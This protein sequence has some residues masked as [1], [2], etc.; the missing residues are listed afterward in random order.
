[1]NAFP[2]VPVGEVCVARPGTRDPGRKPDATFRY[3]DI[4]AVDNSAKKIGTAKT[5]LGRNAPSRA[6]KV[7]RTGDVI[8]SMTRPNLNAVAL[9]SPDLDGEICSTGFG[10]LRATDRILPEYL[11]HFVTSQPFVEAASG[12]VSGALYPAIT[13]SYLRSIPI[14]LPPIEEQRRI[15]DILNRAASIER[16]RAQAS[17]HLLAFIPALFIK[18]F[19][20]P[21]ENP[22]GW[23]VRPLGEVLARIEGGW[24]PRCDDRVP[25]QCEWGVL[26]LSAVTTGTYDDSE[27][28]ALRADT[29]S[30]PEIDVRDGDVLF[31]RKNTKQLVG[32]CAWVRSTAPHRMFP[33]TIF[34]LVPDQVALEPAYLWGVLSQRAVRPAIERIA[35]GAA[36]SMVNI[37][38]GRLLGLAVPVPPIQAQKRFSDLAS[39]SRASS[40]TADMAAETASA[41]SRS[42]MSRLFHQVQHEAVESEHTG[43]RMPPP[44]A[45]ALG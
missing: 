43:E 17:D 39:P 6:R 23:P 22:M 33:Y 41:L 40:H 26:K 38:K 4:A 25:Q 1:M 35:T 21:V 36:A 16:L 11:F 30:R 3:V 24:S 15:V 14:P 28:K 31:S 7:I 32:A 2:S 20:D 37:S 5:L 42:L 29:E 34:R 8:V 27:V 19:G 12:A 13:E 45:S 10:V 18:M 44:A 9:V